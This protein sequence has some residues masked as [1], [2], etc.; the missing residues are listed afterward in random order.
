MIADLRF[1]IRHLAKSP[2]FAAVAI[3]LL[4]LGIGGNTAF[5]SVFKAH[6]LAPFPYPD[7]GRVAQLWC[8]SDAAFDTG[9]WSAPDFRDVRAAAASLAESGAFQPARFNLGGEP[10]ETV[11]GIQCSAGALR[12]LGLAPALGR[13]LTESDEPAAAAPV[14]VLSAACWTRSFGADPAIIGRAIRLNGRS[15]TVVGVA[16]ANFEFHS[17]ATGATPIDLWV[18]LDLT[19]DHYAR[20]SRFLHA[21]GRLKPAVT[22]AQANAELKVVAGRIAAAEPDRSRRLEFLARPIAA[23]LAG[24]S[25]ARLALVSAAAG[26]VLLVACANLAILFLARGAGRQAEYAV[27]LALGGSRARLVRLA[28]VESILV[29][30]LGGAAGCAL[31]GF[32][33]G[34]LANLFPA[35]ST[36]AVAV[37]VDGAVL[38]GALLLTL[39]AAVGAAL[40]PAWM[41]AKTQ[42]V[43]ALKEGGTTQA[44]SRTRHRLLQVLV[45]AQVVVALLLANGAVLLL[46]SYRNASGIN[47]PLA[48]E[49]VV[50]GEV[51]IRGTPYTRTVDRAAFWDRLLERLRAQPGVTGA[52]VTSKLPLRGGNPTS[53]LVDGERYDAT[54]TRPGVEQSF[55]SPGYF[56]AMG[57]TLLRGRLLA[58][59]DG[60]TDPARVGPDGTGIV[61]NRTFARLYWPGEDPL[62]RAV[63]SNSATTY[64]TARVVGVVDDVRQGD[65][66]APAAPEMYFTYAWNPRN[67]AYLVVRSA[68]AA[69]RLV[70]ALERELAALDRDLALSRV[71][72]M[73]ELVTEAGRDRRARLVLIQSFMAAALLMAAIGIY[74]T[75]AFQTRQR[76]REIGVRLALGAAAA[77]IVRLV[78]RQAVPWLVAGGAAG[79]L[80]T[81]ALSYGLRAMLADVD[82]LN[83]A[84]YLAGAAALAAVVA[85]A[86]WL[87]A[88]RAA[89]VNP[90]EALRAE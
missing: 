31:A 71:R 49:F 60:S 28:L 68:F 35:A 86:C 59:T 29:C 84:Y 20:A 55:V 88:R 7:A 33:T 36:H 6:A 74:G 45:S 2:G 11:Q 54:I 12:A 63:R 62:G 3:S 82:L 64:W 73:A 41:A 57:L 85:L 56:A 77:D 1:A 13:W 30:A 53:V 51:T 17:P 14:A 27:R 10:S 80:G 76:T 24:R 50:S 39:I 69:Q 61:V 16:P 78:L 32:G 42:V 40:P 66:G 25:A 8:I 79:M 90:V 47:R 26:L 87:P 48:S 22:F 83:P 37:S 70:P 67:T 72:T 19:D 81:A 52:A 18:P 34:V 15:Y 23:E 5:L 9:L 75:L 58:P 4:A 89:R 44:G 65:P 46:V 43:E 38:G 21:V